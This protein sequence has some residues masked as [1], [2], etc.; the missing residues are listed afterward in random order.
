MVWGASDPVELFIR[1]GE[2]ATP[3]ESEA[4]EPELPDFHLDILKID[5]NPGFDGDHGTGMGD[6]A[7]NS[8]YNGKSNDGQRG[9]RRITSSWTNMANQKGLPLPLGWIFHS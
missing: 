6:A 8:G 1:L 2:G 3:E 5:F 9:K 4:P 7:L